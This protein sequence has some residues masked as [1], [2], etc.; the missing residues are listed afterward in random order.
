MQ[1]S[2][3]CAE[4]EPWRCRWQRWVL[5]DLSTRD[6]RPVAYLSDASEEFCAEYRIPFFAGRMRKYG[7]TMI[8]SPDRVDLYCLYIS[9]LY[10]RH[11]NSGF[12]MSLLYELEQIVLQLLRFCVSCVKKHRLALYTPGYPALEQATSGSRNERKDHY[13]H[14]FGIRP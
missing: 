12:G 4:A 3:G 5:D 7:Y 8:L 10:C 1:P 2:G 6:S 11:I 14:R 13:C 9:R